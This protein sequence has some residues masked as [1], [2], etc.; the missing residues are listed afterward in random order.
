MPTLYLLLIPF[1]Y[2]YS[3]VGARHVQRLGLNLYVVGGL[4]YFFSALFYATLYLQN[5]QP[6][7]P[8]VFR[9]AIA[10]GL[11]FVVTYFFF[12]PTLQDRGV[13]IMAALCQLS[14]LIP[15]LG[16]LLIWHEHPTV[17]RWAGAI[18][19]LVA[20]PL[21][22]LDQGLTD[23][24]LSWRKIVTFAGLVVFNG[25]VLLGPKWFDELRVPGQL[26][27]FM[28]TVFTTAT[29][30]MAL[31]WPLYRGRLGRGELVWGAAI[32][33]AYLG[34]S[35]LVVLAL[36]HF[37]G[38]IVFPFAESTALAMTVAFAALIWKEIPHR[39]GQLGILLVT[40]AA[41]LINL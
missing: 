27:G 8:L 12:A 18:L 33:V 11:C 28:L 38:V 23:T 20:M 41:I 2:A 37:E 25:G 19:C 40:I 1:M 13:S 16:S 36:R 4:N 17:V 30:A 32:S 31:A 10:V 15:M 7:T 5:P 3:S 24:R 34:A 35:P 39:P 29:L 22:S 14:A 9:V 26:S 21:L 6:L